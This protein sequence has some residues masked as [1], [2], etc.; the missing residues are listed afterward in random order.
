MVAAGLIEE[1]RRL[2][3][4]PVPLSRQASQALGYKEVFEHLDGRATLE[5][6]IE[7]IQTRSRQFAKRQLT[8]FRQMPS[9]RPASEELTAALW[10]GTMIS[11]PRIMDVATG[12]TLS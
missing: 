8:W 3:E 6:A 12:K 2:R 1:V 7:Q 4:S 11:D 5:E 10:C 9:C